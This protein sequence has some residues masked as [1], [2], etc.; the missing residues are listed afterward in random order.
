LLIYQPCWKKFINSKNLGFLPKYN[1]GTYAEGR[2]KGAIHVPIAINPGV[3][4]NRHV[5]CIPGTGIGPEITDSVKKI[6]SAAHCPIIFDDI[7]DFKMDSIHDPSFQNTVRKNEVIMLGML[8][9]RDG[10]KYVDHFKV[11][12][13]LG[14]FADLFYAK[15]L[16]G[17]NTRHK[18]VD[19]VVIR[20]NTEGE[21]SGVEHE[22]YPGVVESIK[23]ITREASRKIAEYTFEFAYL[24]GRKKV[25]AVHKAN[26]M[27]LCDGL[28]LEECRKVAE[29]YPFIKY[30]EIIIDNCCMQIVKNP[31]QFDVMVMPNL[32]GSIVGHAVAGICG[33]AGV[34]CGANIGENHVIF[35]QGTRIAGKDIEGKSIANPT[36]MIL[37]S[38]MMLKHMDLPKFAFDI[39]RALEKTYQDGKV[40]TMDLGGSSSLEQFTEEVIANLSKIWVVIYIILGIKYFIQKV[41]FSGW[42][43]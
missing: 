15:T 7:N 3:G 1:F 5:T 32:Y 9:D 2:H 27:K 18:N 22:V 12:Q 13:E 8:Q 29:Q 30:E 34:A 6:L 33:G 26:I 23:I 37:S 35:E 20:E 10:D 16:P 17:V 43:L 21:F 42:C 28:F 39:E 41:Y 19:I 14:C 40:K 25:T 4:S 11:Y 36:A 24:S 38:I 31:W